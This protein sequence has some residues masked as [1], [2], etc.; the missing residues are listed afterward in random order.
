MSVFLSFSNLQ[1]T[2]TVSKTMDGV[3]DEVEEVNERMKRTLTKGEEKGGKWYLQ[4][5]EG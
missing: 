5:Y 4:G 2:K 1:N 3:E